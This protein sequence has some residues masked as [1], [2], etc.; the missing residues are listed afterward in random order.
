MGELET[1]LMDQTKKATIF[2]IASLLVAGAF[3]FSAHAASYYY[4][5]QGRVIRIDFSNGTTWVTYTYDQNGNR[6]SAAYYPTGTPPSD[7]SAGLPDRLWESATYLGS[8]WMQLGWFGTFHVDN[9]T[10]WIYHQQLGW[11]FASGTSLADV[12]FW[13][14]NMNAFWRTSDTVFPNIYRFSDSA[15][16]WYDEWTANPRWFYNFTTAAWESWPGP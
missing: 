14:P 6:T 5:Q 7:G 3:L 8:G 4:D 15:S 9:V 11:L 16:L 1:R 10:G 12:T 13:D 2:L